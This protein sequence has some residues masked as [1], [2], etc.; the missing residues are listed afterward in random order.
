MFPLPGQAQWFTRS[1]KRKFTNPSRPGLGRKL[2]R[3]C[4]GTGARGCGLWLWG[5]QFLL[6]IWGTITH[7]TSHITH[8]TITHHT[9]HHHNYVTCSGQQ[10]AW[11]PRVTWSQDHILTHIWLKKYILKWDNVLWLLLNCTVSFISCLTINSIRRE[12]SLDNHYSR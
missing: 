5:C 11:L 8:H 12:E 1:T 3:L 9:S 10:A 6:S 7:H 2:P 4:A